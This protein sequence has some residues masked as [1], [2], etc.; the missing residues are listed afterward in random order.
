VTSNQRRAFLLLGLS[1]TAFLGAHLLDP[2]AY[3]ALTLPKAA[4]RDWGRLLRVMGYAPTWL[5]F[6]IALWLES[7]GREP[8]SA[9]RLREAAA[10]ALVAVTVAGLAGEAAKLLVRRE[11]PAATE[12]L[13]YLFR[14]FSDRP[15]SGGGLG[16]PSTH[17]AVA[18]A[19]AAAIRRRFRGAG[20]V[21][22]ALAAG[23]GLTRVF[24]QAH[25]LSDA[26]GGALGGWWVGALM[27]RLRGRNRGPL[28]GEA[29]P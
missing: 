21:L 6:A 2:W 24:A 27:P 14:P 15:F 1:I 9:A 10:A 4:D 8:D 7:R 25:F 19:G 3:S 12:G 11:R 17:A 13:G 28:A 22:L 29:A 20:M 18:F 26:V 23:C 5:V 16:M